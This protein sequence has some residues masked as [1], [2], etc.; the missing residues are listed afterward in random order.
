MKVAL[1]NSYLLIT[2]KHSEDKA[3]KDFALYS[4]TESHP[5]SVFSRISKGN[6]E[7]FTSSNFHRECEFDEVVV[8]VQ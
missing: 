3:N 8:F 1:G 5:T 6:H 7:N 2:V 4:A